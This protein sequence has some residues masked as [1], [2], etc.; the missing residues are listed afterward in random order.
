V[1]ARL[2][3]AREYRVQESAEFV[4]TYTDNLAA[5]LHIVQLLADSATRSPLARSHAHLL[6]ALIE[7]AAGRPQAARAE[8]GHAGAGDTSLAIAY[9]AWFASVSALQ[10]PDSQM[11]RIQRDLRDWSAS[12]SETR[13]PAWTRMPSSLYPQVRTY[14][15]GITSARLG[16]NKVALRYA[17]VLEQASKPA[18]SAGLLSDLGLEIRALNLA[19]QGDTVSAVATIERA[20]NRLTY[21]YETSALHRR[22]FGRFLRAE[23]LFAVRRDGEALGWYESLAAF[24]APEFV[25]LAPAYLRMGEIHERRGDTAQAVE[26]YSRFVAR[27]KDCDPELRPLVD[28]VRRRLARLRNTRTTAG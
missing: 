28:D 4:A 10:A 21:H 24:P 5:S 27:W 19:A 8:F 18:G 7:L 14:L 12:P 13:A 2:A 6:R 1:L 9:E 16:E 25:L 3:S 22:F 20:G 17:G 15:L 26:Y 11:R 23:L